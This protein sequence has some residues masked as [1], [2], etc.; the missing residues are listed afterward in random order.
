MKRIAEMSQAELAA[1]AQTALREHSIDS[2]L[3][4]GAAVAFYSKN[5]YTSL[6]IDMIDVSYTPRPKLTRIMQTIGFMEN[7]RYFQHPDTT[8]FVEF[9]GGPLAVGEEPVKQIDDCE[10]ITGML[11]IISPTDCVK[12]R[13]ICFCQ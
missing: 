12:D 9:P 3:T 6:D 11:R 8:Y 5:Q 10:L 7:G 2:V 13:L 1:F 4:G